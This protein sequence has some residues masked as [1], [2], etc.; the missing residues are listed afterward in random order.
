MIR[1]DT[2]QDQ[3]GRLNAMIDR[4]LETPDQKLA[5]FLASIDK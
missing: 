3:I 4:V 1:K 2:G 5:A